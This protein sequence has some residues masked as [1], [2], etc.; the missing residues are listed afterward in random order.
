VLAFVGRLQVLKAPDV[1]LRAAAALVTNRP[2]LRPRLVV[3]VVGGPSGAGV[4]TPDDLRK[5]AVDLGIADL[6][7]F[8]SPLPAGELAD[9]YRAADLVAVPSYNESFGLVALEA[10]ACGIPVVAAAVGGLPTAVEDGAT[11]ALVDGH[12]PRVWAAAI[13]ALLDDPRR[14]RALGIRA[15]RRASEFGW[16]TVAARM[17][18]VYDEVA[19][20]LVGARSNGLNGRSPV[21]GALRAVPSWA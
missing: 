1:L 2:D 17:V 9:V 15:A 4:M 8:L 13:E 6:V 11:G 7:R 3:A 5:L 19:L 18:E 16:G 12:D 21:P 14:R 20:D 10:Q